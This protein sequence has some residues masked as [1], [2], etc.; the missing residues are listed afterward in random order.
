MTDGVTTKGVRLA[1]KLDSVWTYFSEVKSVPEI[2]MSSDK[3]E[4]THLTSESKEYKKDIPDYSSDL[5]FVMNAIPRGTTG[6]NLDLI[7]QLDTDASYEFKVE[8]PQ[9]NQQFV[10]KGQWT[11]RMGAAEVSSPQELTFTV[12]PQAGLISGE[13]ASSYSLTYD[14][15]E[16]SGEMSDESSPYDN[17]ASVTVK[18]C[19][20]TAPE[21]KEFYQWNTAADNSGKAYQPGAKFNIYQ[22]T[23]LYAIWM[24]A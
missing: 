19:T 22:D 11:W 4:F 24:E 1:V 5:E 10:I 17:G 18:E 3:V 12:I 21:G 8:Y 9:E 23:T 14:S 7:H 13:I 2:G 15:N 6:S 20:F 16:G